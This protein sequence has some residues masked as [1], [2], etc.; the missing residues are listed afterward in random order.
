MIEYKNNREAT[1][2]IRQH[3]WFVIFLQ[4]TPV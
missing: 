3:S 1:L 2:P 4:W